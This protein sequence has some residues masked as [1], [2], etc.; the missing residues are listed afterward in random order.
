MKEETL[1]SSLVEGAVEPAAAGRKNRIHTNID[2][3]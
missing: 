1:S 2:R 3:R